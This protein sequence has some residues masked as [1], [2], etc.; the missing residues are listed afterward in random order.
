MRDIGVSGNYLYV[1]TIDDGV[2]LKEIQVEKYGEV[3]SNIRDEVRCIFNK[4]ESNYRIKNSSDFYLCKAKLENSGKECDYI[5]EL[6]NYMSVKGVKCDEIAK[7]ISAASDSA[8]NE[9]YELKGIKNGGFKLIDKKEISSEAMS[10]LTSEKGMVLYNDGKVKESMI[11]KI[12]YEKNK[13][14]LDSVKNEINTDDDKYLHLKYSDILSE[15]LVDMCSDNRVFKWEGISNIKERINALSV[16]DE[17]SKI[18]DLN[19]LTVYD[20]KLKEVNQLL[21][22]KILLKVKSCAVNI[23]QKGDEGKTKDNVNATLLIGLAIMELDTPK[24]SIGTRLA[25]IIAAFLFPDLF[26]CRQQKK[27]QLYEDLSQLSDL[28]PLSKDESNKNSNLVDSDRFYD[29]VHHLLLRATPVQYPFDPL[30]ILSS[31]RIIWQR[32]IK[33]W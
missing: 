11:K 17:V 32:F 19:V 16:K 31:D 2:D 28:I 8:I 6:N 4:V 30:N 21:L 26:E 29:I 23:G 18:N 12:D 33:E 3:F 9:H 13:V 7:L 25:N 22:D 27:E 10:L 24:S 1:S 15:K 20:E 5:Y 14:I